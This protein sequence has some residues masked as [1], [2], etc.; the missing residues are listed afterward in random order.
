MADAFE[1][2]LRA[3][4][5]VLPYA[6]DSAAARYLVDRFEYNDGPYFTMHGIRRAAGSPLPVPVTFGINHA[7]I[8]SWTA[9]R[10]EPDG[11]PLDAQEGGR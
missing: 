2:F 10:V 1:V 6:K 4:E 9:E 3:E 5:G 11:S 8:D 7:R